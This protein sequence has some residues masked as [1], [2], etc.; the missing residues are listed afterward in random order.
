[1]TNDRQTDKYYFYVL[2]TADNFFYGGFANDVYKRFETH[3]NK[4]GAKFTKV[5]S[6]HPLQL[7]YFEEFETKTEALKA[8]YAFKHLSRKDKETF[9][10]QRDVEPIWNKS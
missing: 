3:Q 1:M 7:I 2:Y 9:L 5:N 4:K 10:L 8:E 6:R